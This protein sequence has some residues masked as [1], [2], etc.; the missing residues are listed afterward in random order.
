MPGLTI[1]I[2]VGEFH[3]VYWNRM[4]ANRTSCH[5]Y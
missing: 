3:P 1:D 2:R 4:K 5:E